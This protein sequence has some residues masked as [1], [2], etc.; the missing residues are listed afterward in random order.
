MYHALHF[1]KKLNAFTR[2]LHI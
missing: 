2:A 1:S